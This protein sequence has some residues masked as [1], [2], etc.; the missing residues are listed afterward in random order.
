MSKT[1]QKNPVTLADIAA[2]AGVSKA[3]VS[4]VF[5]HPERVRQALRERVEATA[6]SLGYAG[7]DPKGRLLNSGKVNAIGYVP[8][9]AY[10]ICAAFSSEYVRDLLHG[11]SL[12]CEETGA[13][14]TLVSTTGAAITPAAAIRGAIV[15]GLI[16]GSLEEA[17]FIETARRRNMP[18]VLMDEDGGSDI[19]SVRIDDRGGARLA[20][21]HLLELGHRRFVV[22]T[23][24]RQQDQSARFHAPTGSPPLMPGAYP[25][26]VERLAGVGDALSA[27][28]LSIDNVPIVESGAGPGNAVGSAREGASVLFDNVTDATAVLALSD[29]LAL[30]ALDEASRRGIDVPN[31]LSVVG[32]DDV[33]EAAPAR[34]PLTTIA[35][36][37]EEKGRV[38]ARL[39]FEGGPP[40]QV[41]LPVSL[42]VRSSTAPPR[43]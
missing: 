17:E 43:A 23:V 19:S 7:P 2:S 32:F 14:L 29:A 21:E 41:V 30:A 31:D 12:V 24:L 9:G 11:V 34:P 39:L 5:S 20:T 6:D 15:D 35:Q 36:P 18:L 10:G 37:T 40:R 42:V 3:T 13:S 38:A 27:K 8:T 28:G 22:M 4:N 1:P 16:L 25:I 33:P 26:E